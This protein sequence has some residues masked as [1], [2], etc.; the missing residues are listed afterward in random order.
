MQVVLVGVSLLFGVLCYLGGS[1]LAGSC[2]ILGQR[3]LVLPLVGIIGGICSWSRDFWVGTI[4][5]CH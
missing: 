3:L 4:V 1:V 2:P 5:E